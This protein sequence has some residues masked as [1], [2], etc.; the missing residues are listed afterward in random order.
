MNKFTMLAAAA[1]LAL[2][3]LAKAQDD[4]NADEPSHRMSTTEDMPGATHTS[5]EAKPAPEPE[6]GSDFPSWETQG[7]LDQ[8]LSFDQASENAFY[9]LFEIG[10]RLSHAINENFGG[11][12]QING[13][14]NQTLTGLA[15]AN[16]LSIAP[17]E[18]Y[19]Y[20]QNDS[21]SVRLQFGKWYV[22]IG[23]ELA[24]PPD[25]YQY[26]NSNLFVFFLPTEA[27][28]AIGYF[29]LS[30]NISL[31]VYA[32]GNSTGTVPMDDD[33]AFASGFNS[34]PTIGERLGIS[35][36]D[37]GVGLSLVVSDSGAD[38]YDAILVDVDFSATVAALLIGAEVALGKNTTTD[39]M[40]YGVM[41]MANYGFNDWFSM[42]GRVDFLNGDSF[43]NPEVGITLAPAFHFAPGWDLFTEI[44]EDINDGGGS[45]D[46]LTGGIEIIYQFL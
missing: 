13:R 14:W 7:W 17:R 39:V 26:T 33:F 15:G 40:D 12:L 32:S 46:N 16:S 38:K 5:P 30:D 3:G 10:F 36:G 23:F 6:A 21:E 28:G 44:R 29:S 22:P 18:A 9:G 1:L 37:A 19:A 8:S 25:L 27:V 43:A 20:W 2:P 41:A 11:H 31:A 45:K 34:L 42:T 24:D 35:F 4:A